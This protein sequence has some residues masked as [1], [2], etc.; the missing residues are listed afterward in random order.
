MNV[1]IFG[2]PGSGKGTYASRLRSTLGINVIAT[3]DLLRAIIKKEF[4][5]AEKVKEYVDSGLLVP[6][7]IV[8]EVLKQ[9]LANLPQERGLIF[10]GY[11]RNVKQAKALEK[12]VRIDAII[13][14]LVPDWILIERLSNR[15]ICKKCGEVY[16]IRYLKPKIDMLCNKCGE[17]LYQRSDDTPKVIKDRIKIYESQTQPLLKHYREKGLAFIKS[18]IKKLEI[19]PELVIEKILSSLKKLKLI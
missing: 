15:R 16:N 17:Q 19:P 9:H 10:D 1:I 3:G 14:L 7:D 5:L 6:D 18:E 11:P 2:P 13:Q 12:I 4:L 8:I